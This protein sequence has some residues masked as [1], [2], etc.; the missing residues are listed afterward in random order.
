M[1]A[2]DEDLEG[3]KAFLRDA[4]W[5]AGA[6]Q[7]LPTESNH[8]TLVRG[9]AV[10]INSELFVAVLKECGFAEVYVG[11]YGMKHLLCPSLSKALH[12]TLA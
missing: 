10:K 5:L 3:L 12:A 2:P 11:R 7:P 9:G 1:W 8:S 4:L 6:E